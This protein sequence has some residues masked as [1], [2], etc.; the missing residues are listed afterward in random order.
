MF[1]TSI[2]DP[3][4]QT[5]PAPTRNTPHVRHVTANTRNILSKRL[6]YTQGV[7]LKQYLFILPFTVA[8]RRLS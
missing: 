1:H 4:E 6:Q 2:H 5:W 7:D 3:P 8:L